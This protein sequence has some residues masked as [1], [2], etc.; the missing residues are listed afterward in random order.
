[1]R[2]TVRCRYRV[3]FLYRGLSTRYIPPVTSYHASA[4]TRDNQE[5]R[6][7][8]NSNHHYAHVRNGASVGLFRNRYITSADGIQEFTTK[9]LTYASQ[10]VHLI[11][12]P[13][14]STDRKR[15]IR[16][17]DLLSDTICKVVDMMEFIRF[18]H[19]DSE[20]EQGAIDSFSRM[21]RYMNQLNT[22][23]GLYEVRLRGFICL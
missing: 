15:L 10:L 17:L 19:P 6:A 9:S 20:M 22:H 14:S 4:I 21:Y 3:K 7:A 1:M 23:T 12:N 2:C 11:L 8:F 5:L 16:D 18:V 13:A